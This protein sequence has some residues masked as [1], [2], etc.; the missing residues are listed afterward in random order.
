MGTSRASTDEGLTY[1]VTTTTKMTKAQGLFRTCR[2]S[3]YEC[4]T[5]CL[6]RHGLNSSKRSHARETAD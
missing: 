6:R 1:R 5:R 3:T 2:R 4:N